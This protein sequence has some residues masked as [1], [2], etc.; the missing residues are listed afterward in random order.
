MGFHSPR[1]RLRQSWAEDKH[2][3]AFATKVIQ[4]TQRTQRTKEKMLLSFCP[5][6]VFCG[7]FISGFVRPLFP[8]P[9]PLQNVKEPARARRTYCKL[10]CLGGNANT[11]IV[12]LRK[13]LFCP[14]ATFL[15]DF[16]RPQGGEWLVAR[17][18][19]GAGEETEWLVA[20]DQRAEESRSQPRQATTRFSPRR[21]RRARR[22]TVQTCGFCGDAVAV[23]LRHLLACEIIESRQEILA[24]SVIRVAPN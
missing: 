16:S 19:R 6:A 22:K 9:F 10:P 2:Q 12:F 14:T 20:S 5:L 11:I 23:S 15:M 24:A 21:T 1:L 17:S 13:P 7:Q 18:Q 8:L 4:R 3:N